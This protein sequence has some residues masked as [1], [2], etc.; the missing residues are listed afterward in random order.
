MLEFYLDDSILRRVINKNTQIEILSKVKTFYFSDEMSNLFHDLIHSILIE[1]FFNNPDHWFD[2]KEPM[3]L[4]FNIKIKANWSNDHGL[5]NRLLDRKKKNLKENY[6]YPFG[7]SVFHKWADE[8]KREEL[9]KNKTEEDLFNKAFTEDQLR[10]VKI[11]EYKQ[12]VLRLKPIYLARL[13]KEYEDIISPEE[14]KIAIKEL[15]RIVENEYI[16]FDEDVILHWT[17]VGK[18]VFDDRDGVILHHIIIIVKYDKEFR[19]KE[20]PEEA[21][22]RQWKRLI[23]LGDLKSEPRRSIIKEELKNELPEGITFNDIIELFK[24][25]YPEKM[26]RIEFI[27]DFEFKYHSIRSIMNNKDYFKSEEKEIKLCLECGKEHSEF[28][29]YCKEC[30][31]EIRKKNKYAKTC[32]ECGKV[33]E[34][35]YSYCKE[36][37]DKMTKICPSCGREH[38]EYGKYCYSCSFKYLEES[39]KK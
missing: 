7:N 30:M 32:S 1:C 36:C 27:V 26:K 21:R 18:P 37:W 20:D 35:R 29:A 39:D 17:D 15:R 2:I 28:H 34:E 31:N 24:N 38:I 23:K 25:D 10:K 22:R 5:F 3:D 9:L 33:H 6:L 8:N 19:D 12:K 13:D 16:D 14:N 4:D 11:D